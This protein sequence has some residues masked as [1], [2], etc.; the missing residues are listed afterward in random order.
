VGRFED[1]LTIISSLLR[2][3]HADHDGEFFQAKDA[4]SRPKGP[5]GP[6]GGPPI[7][8]GTNGPRMLKLTATYA[9]AWNAVWHK[10]AEDAKPNIAAVEAACAAVGRDPATLVKTIGSNIARPGYTGSRGN[11]FEGDDAAVAANIAG[12]RDL[13]FRHFVAGID[14]C[15]PQSIEVFA[16]VIDILD[17]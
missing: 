15:T 5:L 17:R 4:I 12:F 16:K 8:V 3:G 1:A 7:L 11:A 2:T 14:P 13:G 10:H 6:S 9:D